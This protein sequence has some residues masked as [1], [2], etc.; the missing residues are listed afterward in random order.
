[1]DDV[2]DSSNILDEIYMG[3]APENKPFFEYLTELMKRYK[4]TNAILVERTGIDK[5]IISKLTTG[6]TRNPSRYI[7]YFIILGMELDM[8]EA[9]DFLKHAGLQW[10]DNDF[11]VIV[12]GCIIRK[13]RDI[14]AIEA[15]LINAGIP[16]K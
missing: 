9:D 11:D 3:S 7:L 13:Y 10:M 5:S 2:N 15:F 12:Q 8:E 14:D 4:I 16:Y 6:R 1:M